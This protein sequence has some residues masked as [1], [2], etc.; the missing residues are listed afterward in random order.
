MKKIIITVLVFFGFFINNL[1]AQNDIS[2]S[3]DK[4][5]MSKL[6]LIE[7]E[8]LKSLELST[9]FPYKG[10]ISDKTASMR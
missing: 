2:D 9:T 5:I 7:Q 3:L 8:Y 6:N 1:I 10:H 4:F